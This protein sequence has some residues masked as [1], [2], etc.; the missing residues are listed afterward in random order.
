MIAHEYRE[1]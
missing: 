1:K